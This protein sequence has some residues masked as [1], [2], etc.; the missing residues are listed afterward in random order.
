MTNTI[1]MVLV[2]LPSGLWA[3]KYEVTRS[4]YT[5]VMQTNASNTRWQVTWNDA[6]EFARRLTD[7]ERSNLPVGNV[8]SLPTQKQWKEFS[9]GQTFEALAE[10]VGAR[11]DPVAAPEPPAANRFG[12]FD[13]NPW[14]WCSDDTPGEEKLLK[15]VA[16]NDK[17]SLRPDEK[18]LSCGFRCV[19]GASES[20]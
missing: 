19:L 11:K 13:V 3:G 2:L 17:L 9:T 14:E 20:H 15:G 10:G 1:G 6:V 8:Y 7:L 5:Q 4:E 12:L 16:F 18:S